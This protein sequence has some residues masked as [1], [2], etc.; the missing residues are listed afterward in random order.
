MNDTKLLKQ[1]D[2]TT[3]TQTQLGLVYGVKGATINQ[4]TQE[5]CPCEEDPKTG[6]KYYSVKRV[7]DWRIDRA[8][9]YRGRG[10]KSFKGSR[11][12]AALPEQSDPEMADRDLGADPLDDSDALERFRRLRGDLTELDIAKRRGELIEVELVRQTIGAAADT[13]RQQ[14]QTLGRKVCVQVAKMSNQ[15]QVEE[16]LTR[17]Y[18]DVLK[19]LSEKTEAIR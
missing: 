5:G 16:L 15:K 12:N 2:F 19:R 6:R 17:Q 3:L 13:I 11:L 1:I 4:W 7:M 9:R 18:E 14:L 8:E 10:R